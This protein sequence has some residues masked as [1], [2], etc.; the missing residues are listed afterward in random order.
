MPKSMGPDNDESTYS[1]LVS[2]DRNKLTAKIWLP[3]DKLAEGD[4][5]PFECLIHEMCHLMTEARGIKGDGDDREDESLVRVISPM[6]YRLYC[7]ENKIK[8]VKEKN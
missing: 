4:D 5:N 7:K 3:A 6:I 1:A 2:Y 8:L